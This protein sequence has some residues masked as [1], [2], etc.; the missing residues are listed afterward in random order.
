M[1]KLERLA[2]QAPVE[3]RPRTE[4]MRKLPDRHRHPRSPAE[5]EEHQPGRDQLIEPI[6][7]VSHPALSRVLEQ[8]E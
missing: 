3:I 8:F 6:D 4:G 1:S 5:V 7:E 2:S